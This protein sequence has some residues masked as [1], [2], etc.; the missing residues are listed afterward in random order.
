MEREP[1]GA[2]AAGGENTA[3]MRNY[4]ADSGGD[5]L[6]GEVMKTILVIDES[7]LFR[8]YL[9]TKLQEQGFEVIVGKDGLDGV[10]KMRSDPPDLII[11]DYHLSRKSSIELLKEK[12]E[13]PNVCSIP[14]IMVASKIDRLKLVQAGKYDVKKFFMKPVRTD[15]LFRAVSELLDVDVHVDTSPCIIEAHLNDDILFVEIARGLNAEKIELLRFRIAELLN[16]YEVQYPRVLLMM[17]DVELSDDDRAKFHTLLDTIIE[18]AGPYARHM[19]I[20]T[21]SEFVTSFIAANP[22]YKMIEVTDN[23]NKAM[24]ELLGLRP[25]DVAHDEVVRRK[26]LST[27]EPRKTQEESFQLRFDEAT[28]EESSESAD[29]AERKSKRAVTV[30][31]VDDDPI[32]RQLIV[33]VFGRTG[34]SILEFENG[35]TFVESLDGQKY[36]LVFL[37]IMMPEMNGFQVLKH[38]RGRDIHFPVIVLSALSQQEAVVTAMRMGVHSFLIKPFKPENLIRKTVEILNSNF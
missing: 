31:V 25:D 38:I 6:A 16:L 3:V 12:K 22:D 35:R 4:P 5:S 29:G 23:L 11:L 8:E 10:V 24:D 7:A 21:R 33:T 2:V 1:R 37:D 28:V 17:T 15:A 14:V 30:A 20:L 13:N 34:W 19:K 27:S 36:D 18:Y 9:T 26:L 32:I